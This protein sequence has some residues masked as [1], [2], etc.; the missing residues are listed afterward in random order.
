MDKLFSG[1]ANKKTWLRKSSGFRDK[2]IFNNISEYGEA[3]LIHLIAVSEKWKEVMA[4]KQYLNRK[5]LIIFR[6][7]DSIWVFSRKYT[8]YQLGS[9]NEM[10]KHQ[11]KHMQM[12]S[13]EKAD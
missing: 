6:I 3:S 12:P 13:R 7:K 5:S 4:E 9:F 11:N 2:K 10:A 1:L 8:Q